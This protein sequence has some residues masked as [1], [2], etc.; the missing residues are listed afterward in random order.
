[1]TT[2][3]ISVYGV[4]SLVYLTK[5]LFIYLKKCKN[6]SLTREEKVYYSHISKPA[7]FFA[8]GLFANLLP[9]AFISRSAFLYHFYPCM[10]F[11]IGLIAT[12]LYSKVLLEREVHYSGEMIL[13]NGRKGVIRK[14][15]NSVRWALG[16][17]VA[18]F[19]LFFPVFS[20][21]PISSIAAVFMFGWANGFWGYG[22]FPSI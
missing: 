12:Y 20:G 3:A 1:M 11:Y 19:F 14:G 21:I 16:I 4:M 15:E 22:L 2:T 8:I 6:N 18:N 5:K 9:W 10:P 13:L 17:C 7:I